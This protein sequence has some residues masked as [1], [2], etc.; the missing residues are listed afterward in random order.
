MHPAEKAMVAHQATG[1]LANQSKI[2]AGKPAAVSAPH[3]P[4][5][6]ASNALSEDKGFLRVGDI[7]IL[8]FE[9]KIFFE[10]HKAAEL[11]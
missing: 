11:A 10:M 2:S 6:T 8:H 9:E 3:P 7:V 1:G 5:A 4:T